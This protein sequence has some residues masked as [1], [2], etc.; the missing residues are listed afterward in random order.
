LHHH[1]EHLFLMLRFRPRGTD[2][3]VLLKQPLV[4]GSPYLDLRLSSAKIPYK[5]QRSH[6]R[7]GR[8]QDP[9]YTFDRVA[10]RSLP[11]GAP[12]SLVELVWAQRA[13]A[14][15]RDFDTITARFGW[16]G[17]LRFHEA[18]KTLHDVAVDHKGQEVFMPIDP[19]GFLSVDWDEDNVDLKVLVAD[20]PVNKRMFYSLAYPG[21]AIKS[22][23]SYYVPRRIVE[24]IRIL[25]KIE[26]DDVPYMTEFRRIEIDAYA[27]GDI[28]RVSLSDLLGG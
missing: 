12:L 27:L 17:M 4:K 10:L 21:S 13:S 15:R 26:L 28:Q 1:N 5:V 7:K 20:T 22:T 16:E 3:D 9:V 25:G 18:L 23:F 6:Y 14:W 11:A 19:L 24:G 2:V 8:F